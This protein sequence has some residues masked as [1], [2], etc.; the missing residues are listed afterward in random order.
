MENQQTEQAEQ[1]KRLELLKSESFNYVRKSLS[2]QGIPKKWHEKK[3]S[4]L[5]G[6][7]NYLAFVKRISNID[8]LN[9]KGIITFAGANSGIGK[10]H[11]AICLYKKWISESYLKNVLQDEDKKYAMKHLFAKERIIFYE[12]MEIYSG[13]EKKKSELTILESYCKPAILVIDD[14]FSNRENEMARRVILDILDERSDWNDLITIITT[15]KSMEE[16]KKIDNRIASRMEND[17]CF[18]LASQT[19]NHRNQ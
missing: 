1:N 11:L 12:L 9:F 8:I 5:Q 13:A 10:T 18:E 2:E 7:E 17:Y 3:F 4:D 15:N 6:D 14:M 16:I 19:V